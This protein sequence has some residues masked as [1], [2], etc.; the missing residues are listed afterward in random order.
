MCYPA[1]SSIAGQSYKMYH[2]KFHLR[3][4][5]GDEIQKLVEMDKLSKFLSRIKSNNRHP[6]FAIK[7]RP[8]RDFVSREKNPLRLFDKKNTFHRKKVDF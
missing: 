3:L 7:K 6:L 2:K 8:S 5:H 1:G 4:I